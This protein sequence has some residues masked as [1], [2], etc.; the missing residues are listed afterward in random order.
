[1]KKAS[2]KL[3]DVNKIYIDILTEEGF[4]ELTSHPYNLSFKIKYH[5]GSK[6]QLDQK[7]KKQGI[8]LSIAHDAMDKEIMNVA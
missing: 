4:E 2:K 7:C 8:Y 6:I 1:M 5:Y 3:V